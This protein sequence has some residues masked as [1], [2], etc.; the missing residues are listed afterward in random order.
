MSSY[1]V[2]LD[3]RSAVPGEAGRPAGLTI[4]RGRSSTKPRSGCKGRARPSSGDMGPAQMRQDAESPRDDGLNDGLTAEEYALLQLLMKRKNRMKKNAGG[5]RSVASL[6]GMRRSKGGRSDA[7]DETGARSA[8]MKISEKAAID[9]PLQKVEE[10]FDKRTK[11]KSEPVAARSHETFPSL[12]AYNSS[13]SVAVSSLGMRSAVSSD[14]SGL[15]SNAKDDLFTVVSEAS[16]SESKFKITIKDRIQNAIETALSLAEK[17]DGNSS[18]S[19]EES[20]VSSEDEIEVP[21]SINIPLALK[22]TR[23]ISMVIS[24]SRRSRGRDGRIA[25][26]SLFSKMSKAKTTMMSMRSTATKNKDP[27]SAPRKIHEIVPEDVTA[28]NSQKTS[29]VDC[30]NK[31]NKINAISIL[32]TSFYVADGLCCNGFGLCCNGFATFKRPSMSEISR[33]LPIE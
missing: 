4:A 24:S 3:I 22:K 28:V 13:A 33:E 14:S 2:G 7:A 23:G 8:E 29:D 6:G 11:I 15:E 19:D 5:G 1:H 18:T 17:A 21:H 27:M 20:D 12:R 26:R 16:E 9:A 30:N 31:V 10:V 25:A 32:A